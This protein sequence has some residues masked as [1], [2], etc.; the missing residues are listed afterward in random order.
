MDSET[1]SIPFDELVRKAD[2]LFAEAAAGKRIVVEY[3]GQ[4]YRITPLKRRGRSRKSHRL[5]PDDPF[6]DLIGIA[7]SHGPGD[8]SLR[9]DD[10]LAQAYYAEFERPASPSPDETSGPPQAQPQPQSPDL[11]SP[12]DHE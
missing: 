5:T 8:V 1:Q 2:S 12:S 4:P 6:L 7:D 9:V 11:S 3:D 10:Y